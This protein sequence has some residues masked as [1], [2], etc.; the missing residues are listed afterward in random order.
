MSQETGVWD[1][2]PNKIYAIGD[3]HGDF[4]VLQHVLEDLAK[5]AELD[6]NGFK[7]I[8]KNS[9]VVFCGDLIDRYRKRPGIHYTVDDENNDKNIIQALINLKHQAKEEGGNVILLLGNHELLNFEGSF[10]YVSENGKY[11]NRKKDF[12]RG[13]DFTKEIANNF[14]LS[15]KI[16]NV[17]YVH[18][19]FCPEAFENNPF[20]SQGNPIEKLNQLIRKYLLDPNFN[21]NVSLLEKNQMKI[22]INALYGIDE[23]KSPLNCR[24]FGNTEIH[25]CEIE[26]NE[27]VFKFIFKE[28][29]KGKMVIAHT[30]QFIS[31]LNINSTCDGKIWRIDVGMS[32]GFDEH[33]SMIERMIAK[34]GLNLIKQLKNIINQDSYRFMAILEITNGNEKIITQ[35]KFSRNILH[36]KKI[37]NS[38]AIFTIYQLTNLKNKIKLDKIKLNPDIIQD[39]DTIILELDKLIEFIEKKHPKEFTGGGSKKEKYFLVDYILD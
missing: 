17:V 37:T 27:K 15:A 9:W 25:N 18:G 10:N 7:W 28:P 8:G 19:G 21:Q 12:K 11:P 31:N 1:I 30:P 32:R 29:N 20:L 26:L 16:G 36:D 3:I 23:N 4:L 33:I 22:L 2:A 5:V 14:F 6:E 13:S 24:H 34:T 35:N 39:K 38:E